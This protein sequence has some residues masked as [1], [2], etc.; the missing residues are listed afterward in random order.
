VILNLMKKEKEVEELLEELKKR[1]DNIVKVLKSC[2][3]DDADATALTY[4]L[5]HHLN[6]LKV[7]VEKKEK[8]NQLILECYA[9]L[10][11]VLDKSLSYVMHTN[12]DSKDVLS[13]LMKNSIIIIPNVLD[14]K[15]LAAELV[16]K[17]LKC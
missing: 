17:V 10:I 8:D 6:N 16:T 2:C 14:S 5:N 13:E 3:S 9:S 12:P 7:A 1:I 11:H 15:K 4:A